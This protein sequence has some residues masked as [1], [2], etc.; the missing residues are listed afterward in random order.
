VNWSLRCLVSYFRENI[1]EFPYFESFRCRV[2]TM[3]FEI[4][5]KV[6]MNYL[7]LS[8]ESYFWNW[9]FGSQ[10]R[11]HS[12]AYICQIQPHCPINQIGTW[13]RAEKG[14]L[15]HVQDTLTESKHFSLSSAI[16]RVQTWAVAVNRWRISIDRAKD[17]HKQFQ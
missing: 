10:A 16:Y 6:S 3:Y 4:K 11:T 17:M 2:K 14:D 15:L 1:H 8:W 7:Y 13:W 12:W 9:N 5:Q